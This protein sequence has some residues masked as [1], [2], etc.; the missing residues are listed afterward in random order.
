[1]KLLWFDLNSSYAHSSLALPALHAQY[2]HTPPS[3]VD[4][5]WVAYS[6]TINEQVGSMVSTIVRHRPDVV[7]ATCWLFNHEVLLAVLARVAALMPEVTIVLGGPEFFG[8]NELFLRHNRYIKGVFRGEGEVVFGQWLERWQCVELW[9]EVAGLCYISPMTGVYCDGE[10]ARVARFDLLAPPE[11]SPFFNWEKPFVQ[12]ETTRGCFN[13]C[14]FCVSGNDRP[15]RTLSVE[16]T[17]KRLRRIM[18]HG[19]RKVRML[20][21]T[22]NYQSSR[23]RALLQLFVECSPTLSFHLEMHPAL[24]SPSLKESLAAMPKGVLHLEAGIQSLQPEVLRLSGRAGQLEAALQGLEFLNALPN[25]ETH[26]DLIAGLPQYSY[27]QLEADVVT[28]AEIDAGEIQLES[29]KL[30]PGTQ[31]RREAKELGLKYSPLPPYEVLETTAIDAD[32]LQRA[33]LLSRLLDGYYNTEVWRES[34]RWFICH[35]PQFLP[36]FI[37]EVGLHGLADHPLSLERRGTILYHFVRKNYPKEA[38]RIEAAWI[39]AGLS[40]RKEAGISLQLRPCDCDPTQWQV[41]RGVYTP[42]IRMGFLP[43]NE[44]QSSGIWYGFDPKKQPQTPLFKALVGE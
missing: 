30:L 31:M 34:T 44:D 6:S 32:G 36:Q 37:N 22:F 13:T 33:R 19:P 10:M 39:E 23:A 2:L 15:V 8:D 11:D 3:G 26:A 41:V 1:M 35:C 9:S 29:L 14:A 20:D 27:P 24:L 16:D 42:N 17:A 25:M 7:A 18:E 4:V 5:E 28:L 38:W 21:R 43:T 12:L 40:L